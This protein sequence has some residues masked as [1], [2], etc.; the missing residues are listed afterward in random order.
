MTTTAPLRVPESTTAAQAACR[1]HLRLQPPAQLSAP[2]TLV[3]EAGGTVIDL[4]PAAAGRE[5]RC[6]VA[7]V[8]PAELIAQRRAAGH[9]V[10]P[11]MEQGELTLS[12]LLP[13]QVTSVA[14]ELRMRPEVIGLYCDGVLVDEE[15][16]FTERLGSGGPR[17]VAPDLVTELTYGPDGVEPVATPQARTLWLPDAR[18]FG[19]YW[20]PPGA[21]ASAGDTM[22]CVEGDELHV[23]WLADRRW[24][25]SKWGVGAHQ[26]DHA[27][28]RDLR[29]WR[30]LPRAVP[31]S[32]P[33]MT[34]GTGS[35]VHDGERF[36]LFW[37]NHGERFRS[38]EGTFVSTSGD[39]VDF[40]V[41]DGFQRHDLI[42]PG[43]WREGDTWRMLCHTQLY[44][45]PDL[46]SWRLEDPNFL[47]M[48]AGVSE[49]CPCVFTSGDRYW[50][51]TGRTGCWSWRHGE[52]PQAWHDRAPY[53]GLMVPMVANWQGR[54]ILAGWVHDDPATI[55]RKHV[56][57]GTLVFRELLPRGDDAGF[58]MRWV[59]EFVPEGGAWT[60]LQPKTHLA[61]RAP[62]ALAL[63]TGACH[64]RLQ[65][66]AEGD[67]SFVVGGGVAGEEGT[68][69]RIERS[70]CR[71]LAARA[72]AGPF[73]GRAANEAFRGCDFALSGITGLENLRQIDLL[74]W[75]DRG[76]VVIDVQLD[77][78]HT[79][80]A[81]HVGAWHG[82][83]VI[84]TRDGGVE[85]SA[86]LRTLG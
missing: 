26:F 85:F 37:H 6:R 14:L 9:W 8:P 67:L 50:L 69:I 83:L 49:E 86:E 42:Q 56:W 52:R 15:W 13:A 41:A 54:L 77:S 38:R 22:V 12:V 71:L 76:G 16:P 75:P 79:L 64:V 63:P 47:A 65:V 80:V 18:P 55:G 4:L 27:V 21:N 19:A 60:A 39:G 24:H 81:R 43:V 30:E 35:C 33:A 40:A 82:G 28:T 23:F 2:L 62:I 25:Q 3:A 58:A 32:D 84:A 1:W 7:L 66:A 61:S 10:P 68:E 48:P 59:P 5:L 70:A 44:T 72:P 53:D 29:T 46:R 73:S 36:H 34:V 17:C 45:S 74:I 78:G 31:I 57:G 11:A 20:R 51:L